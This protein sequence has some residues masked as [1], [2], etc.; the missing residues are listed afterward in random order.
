MNRRL[1]PWFAAGSALLWLT[2]VAF[3]DETQVT[4]DAF[5]DQRPTWSPDGLHLAFDS[6]RSGNQDLWRIPASGGAPTQLT[7]NLQLDQ[8]PDWSPDDAFI[9]FSASQT[10]GVNPDIWIV[11]PAGGAPTLVT[12]DASSNDRFPSVSPDG[13][14][15]AYSK[16]NDIYVVPTAGGTP[17]ALVTDPSIDLHPTWSPDGT[18]IAYLSNASG[19]NDIWVIPAAGGTATQITFDAGNDGAPDWSPD[20]TT[21]AFQSNRSGNNDIWIIPAVGGTATQVTTDL[22]NDVQPDWAPDGRIAFSRGGD[23]WF[24]SFPG[25]DLAVTKDVDDLAPGEGD[26]VTYTVVVTNNGPENATGVVLTDALPTGVTF[27]TANA[28]QGLYSSGTG[29]WTVGALTNGSS[30]TLTIE[31]TVDAGTAGSTITNTAQITATDQADGNAGNDSASA[32]VIV[33]LMDADLS[34]SKSVDNPLPGEKDT[35]TYTIAIANAGPLDATGVEVTDLLPLGVTFLSSSPSQGSYSSGSG[36]WTVGAV[37]ALAGASLDITATVDIGSAG[38]NIVN[39]ATI[40]AVDQTDPNPGDES[41]SASIDVLVPMVTEFQVTSGAGNDLRPAWSNDGATITYDS[42]ASGNQDLWRVPAIGGAPTQITTNLELDQHPDWSP[43]G[44]VIAYSSATVS[45][46]NPDI[47]TIPA[48]GGTPT[49]ITSDAATNDRFPHY[50]PDGTMIAYS[51]GDDIYVVP[52][53]GGVPIPITTDPAVDVHPTWSPDGLSIAFV[54][55]RSGNNDI[56]VIPAAGGTAVQVTTGP[57]NDGAPDW[58]PDG[59]RLAYQSN[60]LGN[61]DIWVIP[62]A[63]GTPVQLTNNLGNDAQPDWSPDGHQIAFSRSGDIWTLTLPGADLAVAKIVDDPTPFEGGTIAYTITLS[64][65]GPDGGSSVEVTDLLPVGVTFVSATPSVGSYAPG[66]GVWSVGTIASGANETLALTAIVD[67][68]TGG[69]VV[70]NTASVTGANEDDNHLAN[71]SASAD[72]T[73][74]NASADLGVTKDVDNAIPNEGGTIVYTI[75]LSNAGPGDAT[76]VEITDLLPVGVTYVSDTPTVGSYVAGTG[77]WTV[78]TIANGNAETLTI[79][80]T[81]DAGTG[82]ST[83]TNDAAVTASDLADPNGTN[84]AASADVTVQ[85]ADLGLTKTVDEAT[86]NEGD[87]ITY[88]IVLENAGP[89]TA[90]GIQI[91]DALP[92]GVTFQSATVSQGLYN[93][94]TGLWFVG[95]MVAGTVDTLQIVATVDLGTAGSTITNTASVTAVTQA[96]PNPGNDT[97]SVDVTVQSIDLVVAK[98]VDVALPNELATIVYTVTVTNDG[99]SDATGVELT[100]LLP[101]GVTYV[102]DVASV[103]AYV[104]GTGV[105]TVGGVANGVT[106]TLDITATVDTGT[107]GST[108]TN[109]ASVTASDQVD[110]DPGNDTASA[111]VTVQNPFVPVVTISS[112]VDRVFTVGAA[113]TPFSPLTIADDLVLGQITAANDLRVH[114]PATLAMEWDATDTEASFAGSAAAKVSTTVS[115][116]D[117]GTTLV[118]D[119]LTDFVAGDAIV[120]S[121]LS[122]ANF[123]AA[124]GPANLELEIGNDG[125][126]TATDDRTVTIL[127]SGPL[128]THSTAIDVHEVAQELWVVNPD[129]GTV[130]VLSAAGANTELLAEIPVGREPWTVACHPSNGEVWV[131][132]MRDDHVYIIDAATRTVVDSLEAGFETYGVAFNPAGTIALVTASGSDEIFAFDVA[133]RSLLVNLADTNTIRRRPRAIAWSPSGDRAW[134]SHLLTTGAVNTITAVFPGSWTTSSIAVPRIVDPDL[135][136]FPSGLQNMTLAPAPADSILWVPMTLLN[137]AAGAIAGNPFTG[138]NVAQATVRQIN[139]RPAG[140]EDLAQE[141]IYLSEG[142]PS[143]GGPIAVGFVYGQAFVANLLSGDVT[144]LDSATGDG[145]ATID[146]GPLPIGVAVTSWG[147][148]YISSLGDHSVYP[149]DAGTLAGF[150]P[151]ST[152]G[153]ALPLSPS[154]ENGRRLFTGSV[155][156]LSGNGQIACASCH[157]LGRADG[158][159]WDFSQYGEQSRN[160]PDLR[161]SVETFA[162]NWTASMDEIQDQNQTILDVMGGA[163]LIAGGGNPPLGAPNAGL[164]QDMDD[165]AAYVATLTHRTDTPFQNPDGSLTADAD[166][167]RVLF[168]D[169][170]VACATCHTGSRFTDSS[171]GFIRHD[172]GT[173]SPADTSGAPGYDTPSLVGVWDTEPYLHD[174]RATSLESVL[175][176]HN[177]NDEHGN[178]SQLSSAQIGFLAAYLRSI[179]E[180]TTTGTDAPNV[181]EALTFSTM[182]DRV[183]PNPFAR[184]TSLRFSLENATSHVRI[185]VFNVQGRRVTTLVDRVLPRGQHVVGWDGRSGS[186]SV[187]APGIYFARMIVDGE[188]RGGK[189]ITVFR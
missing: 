36:V 26:T 120:V 67:L 93:D 182:F 166:S 12:S 3:A 24:L 14:M 79:T 46:A 16:G 122:F 164:S 101:A 40:T 82:G 102:S 43:I 33:G 148:A 134:V 128:A 2:A 49:L 187:V 152:S 55:N 78:G 140:P 85:S 83:I 154:E 71:N 105:W 94:G 69:S 32:D 30:A 81:V 132:S 4:S 189:K 145:I 23:L 21:I 180:P 27:A 129:H 17:V 176:T 118:L 39:V 126:V 156:P 124:S 20:G 64:N 89:S 130:A 106:E 60:I 54:S 112:Q 58:S 150:A 147:E 98:I 136:G 95:N 167:G 13:T 29:E 61:N 162:H 178:T 18:M 11:P 104:S 151:V 96:D 103:G 117:G 185:E 144:V 97:A 8:H 5:N 100:D 59:A 42:N 75:T 70:T 111:D 163:G 133:S 37:A 77:V 74:Q 53:A 68:G 153:F 115:Y 137:T 183:F 181:A 179:G 141:T 19:N 80:A 172:V 113:P 146:C 15:I 125:L 161:G 177:P 86:P 34:L 65:S 62:S 160:T 45:G 7:T 47:W 88:E 110:G 90:L 50:S 28:T 48:T 92:A 142:G 186:G 184:E 119:V 159:T 41:D 169:P 168:H 57:D 10:A 139:V 173:G 170:T 63:G 188:A 116:E 87:T 158:R 114:V 6:N 157:L 22:G 99:P 171:L 143:V 107:S 84:D 174:G 131:A 109:T 135:G 31:A 175:T 165:I 1:L 108:I 155:V 73:V 72:V 38:A 149:I 66:T 52:A 76:G 91:T 123:A 121:G 127:E 138:E 44:D 35:I 51:K 9:A 56:W 25:A